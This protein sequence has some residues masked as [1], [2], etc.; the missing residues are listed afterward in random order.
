[1]ANKVVSELTIPEKLSF[2][3]KHKN[4]DKREFWTEEVVE[5]LLKNE[6]IKQKNTKVF[7]KKALKSIKDFV[8]ANRTSKERFAEQAICT[9]NNSVMPLEHNY[10]TYS[11]DLYA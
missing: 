6:D 3:L 4:R 10:N 11:I 2:P 8:K 5:K 7:I 9:G 1:M